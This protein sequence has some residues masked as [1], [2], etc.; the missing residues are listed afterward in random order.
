M[1]RTE[2]T[3]VA[4]EASL[5]DVLR[6]GLRITRARPGLTL[7][8]ARLL[9]RQRRAALRRDRAEARGVHVPPFVIYSVTGRCNL[10][11]AGCYANLLHRHDRPELAPEETSAWLEEAAR[12]GVS[13]MLLA[14]GEPLLRA[15][16]F[17]QIERRPE[18]LF[19]L[20][21]NGALLDEDRIRWLRRLPNVIP[22]LSLEGDERDTDGR[23]G[24]GTFEHVT[25]AMD[26]L[27]EAGAFFGTSVTLTRTT[28]DRATDEAHLRALIRR[29]CRLFYF[30]NYVPVEPNTD[31]L[32]LDE[33]QV[34]ELERRLARYRRTLGALFIAFPHDEMAFG[35]C[36]A[37]GKGFLHVN[38]YGDVEP[39]PFSPYSDSSL[40]AMSFEQS[41]A[42]PLFRTIRETGALDEADGRCALWKK[43]EWVRS[44][45]ENSKVPVR[46]PIERGKEA[47]RE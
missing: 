40:R 16:V 41:L 44:L 12:L 35:G 10:H 20:F 29:G 31:D 43:R 45:V 13:V 7:R 2:T 5:F 25:A 4:F 34:S 15:D 33:G 11:C 14:G 1:T 9:W 27:A 17:D 32:Q 23:R 46:G 18:I 19:L 28:F 6:T 8:A 37:A 39:C 42:S 26:R 3:S 38:A 36:L 22:V 24:A 47:L 21:S 30:I